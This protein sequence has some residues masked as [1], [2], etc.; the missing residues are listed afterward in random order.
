MA[1]FSKIQV[2]AVLLLY[3]LCTSGKSCCICKCI[4]WRITIKLGI[5][6]YF[7][8]RLHV[9]WLPYS[10]GIKACIYQYHVIAVLKIKSRTI[11][12]YLILA[13]KGKQHTTLVL[14]P[15]TLITNS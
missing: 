7:H 6:C 5:T 11:S 9:M 15:L 3:T 10:F 2:E 8:N 13:D 14:S 12:K 4:Q 1:L